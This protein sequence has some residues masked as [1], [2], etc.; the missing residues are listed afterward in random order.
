[1]SP[2]GGTSQLP[3]ER[4]ERQSLRIGGVYTLKRC[5]L[6]ERRVLAFQHPYANGTVENILDLHVADVAQEVCDKLLCQHAHLR[7]VVTWTTKV[8]NI[9]DCLTIE[10]RYGRDPEYRLWHG[11]C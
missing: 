9:V 2:D 7:W 4:S 3:N 11:L 1:V 5:R 10:R 6:R 8:K